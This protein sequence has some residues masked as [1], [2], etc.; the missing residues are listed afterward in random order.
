MTLNI[1]VQWNSV[2]TNPAYNERSDITNR[3]ESP[4]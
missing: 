1:R 3:I 2:R 4:V